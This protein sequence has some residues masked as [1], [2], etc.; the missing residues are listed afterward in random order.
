MYFLGNPYLCSTFVKYYP[1]SDIRTCA[2]MPQNLWLAISWQPLG[3][4]GRFKSP[5]ALN[6]CGIKFRTWVPEISCSHVIL[7]PQVAQ[8][9]AAFYEER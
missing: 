3:C 9:G 1:N 6:H 8:V 4:F 5:A 7:L 2:I